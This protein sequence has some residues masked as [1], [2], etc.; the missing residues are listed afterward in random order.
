MTRILLA[1]FLVLLPSVALA[2]DF[3]DGVEALSK[4]DYDTAIA[5]FTAAIKEDPRA[6]A[7]AG[8]GIAYGYKKEYGKAIEDFSEAIRLDPKYVKNYHSRGIA[9]A[10]KKEYGKAIEDFSEA[11]RLEPKHAQNY[12]SRGIV[13]ANKKEY[14][15]AIEDFSVTI[16]LNP[17][18]I[19]AYHGRGN[20]YET[21]KQYDKAIED[22]SEA[23]RLD[24]KNAR[25]YDM[26]AS[27]LATCPKDSVRDGKKAVE[28]ATKACRLT[29]WKDGFSLDNLAAAYAESGDFKEA[30]RRQKAVIE[31][32]FTDKGI[33]EGA[34]KRLALYQ[35]GKPYRA[36]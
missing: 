3:A 34:R 10:N 28:Y 22:F 14:G 32:G 9:Y 29:D 30:V 4:K 1:C 24:P 35:A 25:G 12:H 27:M 13:Y 19:Y 26:L 7:F 6:A 5:S 20:A 11:I 2:G 36:K 23:I 31:L 8:R 16:R 33:M 15:K 21:T 18:D 17:K